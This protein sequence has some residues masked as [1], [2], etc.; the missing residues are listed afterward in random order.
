MVQV[1]MFDPELLFVKL[2]LSGEQP[3]VT[4]GE[5]DTTGSASILTVT[6]SVFVQPA[7]LVPVIV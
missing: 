4:S 3:I 5:N 6:W 1:Q 7:A 2:T